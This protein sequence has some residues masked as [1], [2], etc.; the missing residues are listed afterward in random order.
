MNSRRVGQQSAKRTVPGTGGPGPD[1]ASVEGQRAL[2]L[3]AG[4]AA[5]AVVLSGFVTLIF[6]RLGSPPLAVVFGVLAAISLVILGWA[7]YRKRR[8]EQEQ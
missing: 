6:L 2:R 4:I 3:H 7:L 8:G 5:I 1:E